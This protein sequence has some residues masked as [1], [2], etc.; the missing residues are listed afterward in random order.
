MMTMCPRCYELYS[1]IWSKPCCRC[2]DK[3]VPVEPDLIISV[4]MFLERGFNVTSATYYQ[5]G[6]GSDCI[7]IE[8]RFGKLY[9][10]NLFS[11]LIPYWSV[12]DEY[13]VVGDELG[14]PHSILSCRV[15]HT[16]DESLEA[17]KD[18][19]IRSLERWLDDKDPQACKALIALSG[20]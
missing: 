17:Q 20:C 14:E 1:E 7:E 13:P 6:T 3:T 19:A 4:Q 2:T 9:S 16:P 10:D 12:T 15:D 5:E 18:N 11:E 8:F